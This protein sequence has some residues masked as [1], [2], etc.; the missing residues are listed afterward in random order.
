MFKVWGLKITDISE[1]Q[2][3]MVVMLVYIYFTVPYQISIHV[4]LTSEI[5]QYEWIY[6]EKIK[7]WKIKSD[8][9]LKLHWAMAN[10]V[11]RLWQIEGLLCLA[12]TVKLDYPDPSI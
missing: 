12:T 8:F 4:F 6:D 10:Q 9:C 1:M 3:H 7:T 11:K 2:F 5:N